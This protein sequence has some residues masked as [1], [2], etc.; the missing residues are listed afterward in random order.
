[1]VRA[2]TKSD[3]E[4]RWFG[5]RP[6]EPEQKTALVRGVFAS[7]ASRYDVMNDLMSGGVHRLWKARFI[8][9]VRPRPGERL[10]DVAG[11]TGDIALRFLARA[12]EGASAVICDLSPEMVAVGRDR[13]IDRGRVAGLHHVVGN[14][15]S[16]PFADRSFDV[17]TIAFGLRNVT[18]ID[19]ALAEARRVL[20]PGGR[21]FC[22]E[23]SHVVLPALRRLYDAYSFTVIP[24]LGQVVARDR[25]ESFQAASGKSSFNEPLMR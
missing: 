22:L 7:V 9:A 2:M 4:S 1:M 13:A 15:E 19:A 23:F 25:E 12:G 24:R 11:G 17:Y 3:P 21:F 14:A 18:H 6:V 8:E 20:K 5:Y 10:L 16:L